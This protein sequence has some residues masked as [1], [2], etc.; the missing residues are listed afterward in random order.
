[1]TTSPTNPPEL[2]MALPELTDDKL[3]EL[4]AIYHGTAPG[5]EGA[6]PSTHGGLRAVYEHLRTLT[7]AAPAVLRAALADGAEPPSSNLTGIASGPAEGPWDVLIQR[8]TGDTWSPVQLLVEAVA[9]LHLAFTNH[10]FGDVRLVDRGHGHV[11]VQRLPW[12]DSIVLY[13][14]Q[15]IVRDLPTVNYRL[16][17]PP[18][19]PELTQN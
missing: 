8:R 5:R 17:I 12:E 4:R 10:D 2:G 15:E 1:M 11:L 6:A 14:G 16:V 19:P 3:V 13:E 7:V 18:V 9:V